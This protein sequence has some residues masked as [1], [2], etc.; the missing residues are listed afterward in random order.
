MTTMTNMV[1]NNSYWNNNSPNQL[2]DFDDLFS[3]TFDLIYNHH[4]TSIK[5]EYEEISESNVNI[6]NKIIFIEYLSFSI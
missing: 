4:S 1:L 3:S 6:F 5:D 2:F